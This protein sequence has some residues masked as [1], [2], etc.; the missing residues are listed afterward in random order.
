MRL[1]VFLLL[2]ACDLRSLNAFT[3]L[4]LPPQLC[5]WKCE[6]FLW[7]YV[8]LRP[9][10]RVHWVMRMRTSNATTLT[11]RNIPEMDNH[12]VARAMADI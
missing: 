1:L 6:Q 4:P 3:N 10:D 12:A 9:E 2:G 8:R 11:A 5:R 7:A